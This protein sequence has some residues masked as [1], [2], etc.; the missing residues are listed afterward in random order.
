MRNDQAHPGRNQ[1]LAVETQR[2]AG[3]ESAVMRGRLPAFLVKT[4][5]DSTKTAANSKMQL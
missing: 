4:N 3:L 5:N 1:I 2:R